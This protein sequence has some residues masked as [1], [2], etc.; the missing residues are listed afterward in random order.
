MSASVLLGQARRIFGVMV[1]LAFSAMVMVGCGKDDKKDNSSTGGGGGSSD[2]AGTYDGEV[3]VDDEDEENPIEAQAKVSGKSIRITGSGVD[4]TFTIK[5]DLILVIDQPD[6]KAWGG[7][8]E[9]D[10]EGALGFVSA[11]AGGQTYKG[12]VVEATKGGKHYYFSGTNF[13]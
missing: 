13:N 10:E 11:K 8:I 7:M 5:G 12:L 1:V 2:I 4:V 3:Y 6:S 9:E